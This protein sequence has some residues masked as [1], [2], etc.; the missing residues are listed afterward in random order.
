MFAI[1]AKV[2][3]FK[4]SGQPIGSYARHYYDLACL[5]IQPEVVAMLHGAEYDAIKTDY[6][7]IS[8]AAFPRGYRRPADT[9]FANSEALFPPQALSAMLGVEYDRQCRVLCYDTFPTWN[10][11]LA[12]FEQLRGVL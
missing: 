12:H 10:D 1:H 6:E 2:E 4:E 11:V 7:R 5:I 9:S 8:L 3:I